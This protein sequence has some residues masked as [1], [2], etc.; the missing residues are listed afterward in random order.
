[1]VDFDY[2]RDAKRVTATKSCKIERFRLPLFD[3]IYLLL[4]EKRILKDHKFTF[5]YC[6]T[7]NW[8]NRLNIIIFGDDD[9][10]PRELKKIYNN[11]GIEP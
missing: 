7:K 8:H 6:V 1:M 9:R 5:L 11:L 2:V 10:S 3:F 4:D